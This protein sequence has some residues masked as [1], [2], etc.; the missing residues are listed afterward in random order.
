MQMELESG[1]NKYKP[2]TR[3]SCFV[4][5]HSFSLLGDVERTMMQIAPDFRASI[6]ISRVYR[7]FRALY[8]SN[9]KNWCVP[10]MVKSWPIQNLTL[11]FWTII[12]IFAKECLRYTEWSGIFALPPL[13]GPLGPNARWRHGQSQLVNPQSSDCFLVEMRLCI[14]CPKESSSRLPIL[15][16]LADMAAQ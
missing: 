8:Y 15:S 1:S 4:T 9:S 13:E 16:A 6:D 10:E 5:H 2:Q 3:S 11:Q 7:Y 14:G 12:S